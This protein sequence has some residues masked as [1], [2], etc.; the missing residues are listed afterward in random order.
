MTPQWERRILLT[1]IRRTRSF[2][3]EL[4]NAAMATLGAHGAKGGVDRTHPTQ[5]KL[6]GISSGAAV[7]KQLA[8]V[9]EALLDNKRVGDQA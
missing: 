3:L 5:P 8:E 9:S 2:G 1:R 4:E 6:L 7:N